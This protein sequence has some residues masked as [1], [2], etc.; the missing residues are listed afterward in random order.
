MR[1]WLNRMMLD[2]SKS[3]QAP[4]KHEAPISWAQNS[5]HFNQATNT[6]TM[7]NCWS[8]LPIS[9]Q[10]HSSFLYV[11]F[12]HFI[13]PTISTTHYTMPPSAS[14]RSHWTQSFPPKPSFTTKNVP[15]DL[16]G[17]VYLVTGANSGMGYERAHTLYARSAK[18]YVACR[19]EEKASKAIAS[20]KKPRQSPIASSSFSLSTSPT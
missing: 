15:G 12:H 3:C 5:P 18:V 8:L 11:A 13:H 4:F 6:N 1:L 7:T 2:S 19:S 10:P 20:I 14:F 16:Q 9:T 17:K